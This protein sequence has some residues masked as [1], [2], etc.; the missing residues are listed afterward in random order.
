MIKKNYGLSTNEKRR[1]IRAS[2]WLVLGFLIGR[3]RTSP[4][5]YV[6]FRI[7]C[8]ALDNSGLSGPAFSLWDI[9]FGVISSASDLL[10]VGLAVR[11]LIR[12]LLVGAL[13]LVSLVVLVVLCFFVLGVTTLLLRESYLIGY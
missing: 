5:S 10:M 4:P 11:V 12:F 6:G 8:Y 2:F 13:V 1:R 9:G 3:L 7:L